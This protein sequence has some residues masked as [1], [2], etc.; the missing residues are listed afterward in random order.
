MEMRSDLVAKAIKDRI[1]KRDKAITHS[2]QA[3]R[4]FLSDTEAWH[5]AIF[6]TARPIRSIE[7]NP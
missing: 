1:E 3:E 6:L 5:V 2:I 7:I 4:Q